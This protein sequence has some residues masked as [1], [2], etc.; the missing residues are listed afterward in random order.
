MLP[1]A[2]EHFLSPR[3]CKKAISTPYQLRQVYI[4][5]CTSS[6]NFASFQQR[7]LKCGKHSTIVAV[8]SVRH[9]YLSL[10]VSAN[11]EKRSELTTQL[12]YRWAQGENKKRKSNRRMAQSHRMNNDINILMVWE[13]SAVAISTRNRYHSHGE[14][15]KDRMLPTIYQMHDGFKMWGNL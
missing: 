10:Y 8:L 2:H 1:Y 7:L 13:E 11:D 14:E 15:G 9:S 5:A 3:G 6:E 12:C 4:Q